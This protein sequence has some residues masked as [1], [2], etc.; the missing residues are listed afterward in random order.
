[1]QRAAIETDIEQNTTM[2]YRAPEQVDLYSR[3]L[4]NEKVDIWALG[5]I[6]YKLAFFKG[7]FDDAGGSRI[8][9]ARYDLPQEASDFSENIPRFIRFCLHPNPE[10]RPDI[11]QVLEALDDLRNGVTDALPAYEDSLGKWKD[12]KKEQKKSSSNSLSVS[13]GSSG[14]RR[15]TSKGK[16]G[17]KRHTREH[18]KQKMASGSFGRSRRGGGGSG[19]GSSRGRSSRNNDQELDEEDNFSDD[20]VEANVNA[21]EVGSGSQSGSGSFFTSFNA[22]FE[23]QNNGFTSSNSTSSSGFDAFGMATNDQSGLGSSSDGFGADFSA[24]FESPSSGSGTFTP[25]FETTF[26]NTA[27]S[28]N[29]QN[30]QSSVGFGVFD[31]QPQQTPQPQPKSQSQSHDFFANFDNGQPSQQHQQSQQS[32]TPSAAKPAKKRGHQR[33]RSHH[34]EQLFDLDMHPSDDDGFNITKIVNTAKDDTDSQVQWETTPAEEALSVPSED[35]DRLVALLTDGKSPLPPSS[36]QLR[37]AVVETWRAASLSGIFNSMKAR[38]L[39][40][41][42]VVCFK[43]LMVTHTIIQEGCTTAFPQF[44]EHKPFLEE[45]ARVW[46]ASNSSSAALL[47]EYSKFIVGKL[48]FHSIHPEFEPLYSLD[49]YLF[50]NMDLGM[51]VDGKETCYSADSAAHLLAL[52]KVL[53]NLCNVVMAASNEGSLENQTLLKHTLIPL[54]VEMCNLIT[55]VAHVLN[56]QAMNNIDTNDVDG[57]ELFEQNMD[58]AK[59][60]LLAVQQEPIVTEEVYLDVDKLF[61]YHAESIH[62]LVTNSPP[63]CSPAIIRRRRLLQKNRVYGLHAAYRF[64]FHTKQGS[65]SDFVIQSSQDSLGAQTDPGIFGAS[66]A[67][68]GNSSG[69]L[70]VGISHSNSA[71]SLSALSQTTSPPTFALESVGGK[72]EDVKSGIGSQFASPPRKNFSNTLSMS[73][74]QGQHL[75][76]TTH[77]QVR[78]TSRTANMGHRRSMSD[79]PSMPQ[80]GEWSRSNPFL[81]VSQ[82]NFGSSSTSSNSNG[83][84]TTVK[85]TGASPSDGFFESVDVNPFSGNANTPSFNFEPSTPKQQQSS[86]NGFASFNTPSFTTGDTDDFQT[87]FSFDEREEDE[88][89]TR[90]SSESNGRSSQVRIREPPKTEKKTNA[91]ALYRKRTGGHRRAVSADPSTF[92]T[93]KKK[94]ARRRGRP[95]DSE[96]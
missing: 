63:S 72:E 39:S 64:H 35:T 21:S 61:G 5:C 18:A 48:R 68:L 26:D 70:G 75:S 65:S 76:Q 44:L 50:H 15:S 32:F 17:S 30:S 55:V 96:K 56:V 84:L 33:S 53:I 67:D 31:A 82:L 27:G 88:V 60:F 78:T 37:V 94:G 52:L 62:T 77:K 16:G 90:N 13:G 69:S 49:G 80:Q 57:V 83:T 59:E 29:T 81:D 51:P 11:D 28:A 92:A 54:T 42:A 9:S 20:E 10:E 43:A 6:L 38:P 3:K 93:M 19:S 58:L 71:N 24:N 36:A 23:E 4:I 41:N 8:M 74:V 73:G 12:N 1:M 87:S 2:A 46:N 79:M 25:A 89:N 86:S 91:N 85:S 40:H 45:L 7:P 66:S 34:E 95:G 14:R 22:Q 47:K